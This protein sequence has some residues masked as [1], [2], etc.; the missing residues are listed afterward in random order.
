MIY[1]VDSTI[2]L[3]NNP[4][5]GPVLQRLDSAIRRINLYPVDSAIVSL[6]LIRWIAI[7]PMDSAIYLL[8]KRDLLDKTNCFFKGFETD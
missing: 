1:P 3:L 6:I 7:Y 5:L 8:N 2:H 4:G